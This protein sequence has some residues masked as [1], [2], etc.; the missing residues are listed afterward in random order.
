MPSVQKQWLCGERTQL[1]L[2]NT[3]QLEGILPKS[4]PALAYS[5]P[6]DQLHLIVHHANNINGLTTYAN[7]FS[8]SQQFHAY[9][10]VN[11]FWVRSTSFLVLGAF[12][13]QV[14]HPIPGPSIR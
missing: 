3:T 10:E 11:R 1:I 12:V 4:Q 13:L 8:L 5:W 14:V 7:D 2:E 9:P 6:N